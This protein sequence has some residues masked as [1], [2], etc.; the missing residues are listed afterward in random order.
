MPAGFA[1]SYCQTAAGLPPE[2]IKAILNHEVQLLVTACAMCMCC[3][4]LNLS[5]HSKAAPCEAD[6]VQVYALAHMLGG[7][8]ASE[9]HDADKDCM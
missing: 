7:L 6:I 3:T 9:V 5:T 2:V 1:T 4:C 8:A